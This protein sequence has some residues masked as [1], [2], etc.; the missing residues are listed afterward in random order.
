[1]KA[2]SE[3]DYSSM[4]MILRDR[5][6]LTYKL[7]MTRSGVHIWLA[8]ILIVLTPPYSLAFHTKC[9]STHRYK[10][11]AGKHNRKSSAHRDYKFSPSL[12]EYD[13]CEIV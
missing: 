13:N 3:H 9:S 12:T 1:M 10:K 5:K 6:W 2:L 8:G 11:K 7:E 4:G